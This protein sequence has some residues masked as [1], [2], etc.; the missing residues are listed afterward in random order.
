MIGFSMIKMV[1]SHSAKMDLQLR[2]DLVNLYHPFRWIPCFLHTTFENILK[3][4][5]KHS[6]I[7]EF[8]E[9]DVMYED[10]ATLASS[11]TAKPL[12]S[13]IK[14]HY[15]S[16]SSCSA[17][18]TP[19][20]IEAL[21]LNHPHVKKIHSDRTVKALLDNAIPS[22]KADVLHQNNLTGKDVT[23]AIVDTG[24]YPH[25]DLKDR[26][27]FFKDFVKSKSAPYDD[28]GHGTHVSGDA[29]GNGSA[30]NGQYTGVAPDANLI[31]V[32]VLNRM[33]SG[34]LSTVMAG[35]QW[36]IDNRALYNINIISMSLGS[37]ATIPAAEDPMVKVVEAAWDHGIVVVV[38]AGN[39]GP[40]EK[41]ISSPGIS[42]KVITV[43]AMNDMNTIMRNDDTVADFSSRGPTIDGIT[44]PDV[45]SPGVNIVSLRSPNSYLDKLNKSSRVGNYYFTLSGTSMATPICAGLIALILQNSPGLTPDQVKAILLGSAEN[46]G[47]PSNVQGKGYI[48]AARAVRYV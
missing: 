23:I 7:I 33:G 13:N 16:V 24:I 15:P 27:R 3:R 32:K 42:P 18:L 19:N 30:S 26:I 43:G 38:A 9:S 14:H 39:D 35:I 37:P 28:N 20:A 41:T 25:L 34:S 44:K 48:D 36:C 12:Q 29:A 17:I 4:F 46:W 45:L 11:I 8:E 5:K 6:V 22:I 2:K 10:K 47:L 31:G 21:L 40:D 1:R